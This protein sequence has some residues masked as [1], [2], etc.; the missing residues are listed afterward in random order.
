MG[1][2]S[3][4]HRVLSFVIATL[5]LATQTSSAWSA[6]ARAPLS[7]Y[8]QS[9][10]CECERDPRA[11]RDNPDLSLEISHQQPSPRH[12]LKNAIQGASSSNA[13]ETPVQRASSSIPI[14][15]I[16]SNLPRVTAFLPFEPA[17]A[18][19][20]PPNRQSAPALQYQRV[21]PGKHRFC[22]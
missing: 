7:A 10:V 9:H 8:P 15:S 20:A 1:K 13:L 19:P 5:L 3:T 6:Y 4:L 16:A 22:P 11:T 2:I 18:L 12:A 17:A 14:E 21:D